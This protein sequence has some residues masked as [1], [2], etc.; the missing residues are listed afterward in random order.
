MKTQT[1]TRIFLLL[2]LLSLVFVACAPQKQTSTDANPAEGAC[3]L[4]FTSPG[5][6]STFGEEATVM[7]E[8]TDLHLETGNFYWFFIN[9]DI[10][11]QP[12][13]NSSKVN[14]ADLGDGTV[15]TARVQ[16][17]TVGDCFDD[18]TFYRPAPVMKIFNTPVPTAIPRVDC[19]LDIYYPA[20]N[21]WVAPD[22]SV[23]TAWKGQPGAA[24]Y[25]IGL[26]TP[27]GSSS[28]LATSENTVYDVP[29]YY[30]SAEG[31]YTITIYALKHDGTTLC[32]TDVT[33]YKHASAAA[34]PPAQKK[35]E[36]SAQD[37]PSSAPA[38]TQASGGLSIPLIILATPTIEPPK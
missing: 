6:G 12:Y 34:E 23:D 17:D 27:G 36:S 21:I 15:F 25:V 30:Y 11:A 26:K 29:L 13:A 28:Q 33:V 16:A 19:V 38:P 4:H 31:A 32:S 10:Y 1:R 22:Q 24:S 8:W 5:P 18:L 35:T 9:G 14:M 37:Q 7:F 20:D 2:G 3:A